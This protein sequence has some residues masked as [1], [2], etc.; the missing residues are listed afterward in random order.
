MFGP[1]VYCDKSA[2]R[3]LSDAEARRQSNLFS[4]M[5][6]SVLV[7][8]I[9]GEIEKVKLDLSNQ[10][11]ARSLAAKANVLHSTTIV[12]WRKMC[13]G[14]LLR[15]TKIEFG[16]GVYRRIVREG[17]HEYMAKNGGK[18]IFYDEPPEKK[19]LREWSRGEWSEDHQIYSRAWMKHKRSFDLTG[20]RSRLRL[21][22]SVPETPLQIQGYASLL[23]ADTALRPG[24]LLMLLDLINPPA[25]TRVAIHRYWTQPSRDWMAKCP[26]A[27]HCCRS[28]LYMYLAVSGGTINTD[29]T[30][31]IDLE[32]LMYLPFCNAF[33][34]G[35]MKT[36]GTLAPLLMEP[37]QTF[38]TPA[39]YKAD[40]LSLDNNDADSCP[41]A[42]AIWK[43]WAGPK[44]IERWP[45]GHRGDEPAGDDTVSE[46]ILA[47]GSSATEISEML[48]S[49][50]ADPDKF[51]PARPWPGF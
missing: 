12:D 47:G 33:V 48:A 39:E 25:K 42:K 6:P 38:L 18:G 8:E 5:I 43:K 37:D 10:G 16:P 50:K 40:L 19:V 34:S 24:M 28:L 7:W 9:C 46:E 15:M 26:Y 11:I 4:M 30:N 3:A 23:I 29:P 35:D 31:M 2:I 36:H 41:L 27:K 45:P 17:G 51:P 32:Y 21:K 1:V 22:E 49:I 14:E 20:Y 44:S 13:L